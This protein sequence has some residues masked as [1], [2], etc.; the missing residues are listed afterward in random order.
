MNLYESDTADYRTF[1]NVEIHGNRRQTYSAGLACIF[2]A[3]CSKCGI[4]FSIPSSCF[5]DSNRRKLW[6]LNVGA[7]LGQMET[8]GRAYHLQQVMAISEWNSVLMLVG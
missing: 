2:Q 8:G 4:T 7:V 5:V 6:T 3:R 1:S